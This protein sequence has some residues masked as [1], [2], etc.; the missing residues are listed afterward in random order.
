MKKIFTLFLAFTATVALWAYDFKSG[1]LYYNIISN[2]EPYE[3]EVT[4]HEIDNNITYY[5]GLVDAIIPETV[6]YNG[7]TYGVTSI[8][9]MAFYNCKSLKSITIP[10]SVISIGSN[11]FDYCSSLTSIIIP[12]SVVGIEGYA[13]ANCKSLVSVSIPNSLTSIESNTFGNCISLTSITI[14]NSVTSIGDNAFRNCKSLES[15]IIPN[16][17]ISIEDGTFDDCIFTKDKFINQSSLDAEA[18]DYWGAQ[19]ADVEIEGLLIKED[20]LIGCRTNVTSVTI[21]KNI[22]SVGDYA[23]ADCSLLTSITIPYGVSSIGDGTFENCSSLKSITI[24]NSVMDMG[25]EYGRTFADCSSLTSVTLSDRVGYIGD[26]TFSGCSSLTSITI[27]EGVI[28]IGDEAFELCS[29]L[30][31]I[32]IPEGV[33]GI[34]DGAFSN[35]ESLMSVSIPKSLEHLGMRAFNYCTSIA[36]IIIDPDNAY[37]DSR[38]NCNAIIETPTNTLIVGCKNT[39]IPNSVTNIGERAFNYCSGLTSIIIPNSVTSIGYAAFESCELLTSVTMSNSV[40]SIGHGAFE[41]CTSLKSITIP[42]SITNIGY[43]T[44]YHCESLASISIP[45]SVTSIGERAFSECSLLDTIYCY[46][47]TPPATEFK[48]FDTFSGSLYVPCEALKNYQ[49]H[50]TWKRFANVECIASE[51]V[52]TD[53]AMVSTSYNE[54]TITWPIEA[55]AAVYTIEIKAGDA[56]VCTL[57]FN[58]QGQLLGIAYAQGRDGQHYAQYAE[59]TNRGYRFTITGLEDA[60]Q[61]TY[62]ITVQDEAEQTIA[63]HMGEF[64]TDSMTEVED[65]PYNNQNNAKKTLVNGQLIIQSDEKMYNV[66]GGEVR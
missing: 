12:A 40:T 23:F 66:M 50:S 46:A 9:D 63:T 47:T 5:P 32:I 14:P 31:S 34:G 49:A 7:T 6:I 22:E 37:Y 58:A 21:P 4:Y 39:I 57:R 26:E 64:T 56:V 61:Y 1:D 54:V 28:S 20:V 8:G 41:Y 44:F 2:Q 30:T 48:S 45:N 55:D 51:E 62:C 43:M 25:E 24:P 18:N 33:I 19:I 27:P 52:E 42:N 13:F 38:D 11:A 16:S 3:V 15:I 59:Q 17:V 10:N 53:E 65:L 60:T 36:T 29:S 35:C